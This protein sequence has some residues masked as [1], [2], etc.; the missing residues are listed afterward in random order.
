ML[1]A[2]SS[3]SGLGPPS[4]C[5]QTGDWETVF[6]VADILQRTAYKY[7]KYFD[8]KYSDFN[9]KSHKEGFET[10]QVV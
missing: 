8:N 1:A 5:A 4:L 2:Q 10:F 9:I 7:G 3:Q 6:G